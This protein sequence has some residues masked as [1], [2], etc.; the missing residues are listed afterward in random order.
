MS[1]VKNLCVVRM[2]IKI[3]Y[4]VISYGFLLGTPCVTLINIQK[5]HK[6]MMARL[7]I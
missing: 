4:M 7:E 6:L 5:K 2:L 3:L 1:R